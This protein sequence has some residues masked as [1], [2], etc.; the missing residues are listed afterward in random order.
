[1]SIEERP[2]T[3]RMAYRIEVAYRPGPATEDH[4]IQVNHY[5]GTE[6]IRTLEIDVDL[7]HPADNYDDLCGSILQDFHIPEGHSLHLSYR[8]PTGL[9]TIKITDYKTFRSMV[10]CFGRRGLERVVNFVTSP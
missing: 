5:V 8:H 9:N 10:S 2:E 6:I 3:I 1:M 4:H 7:N